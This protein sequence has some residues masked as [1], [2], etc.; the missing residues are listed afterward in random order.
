MKYVDKSFAL[1]GK[2]AQVRIPLVETAWRQDPLTT[3]ITQ[4]PTPSKCDFVEALAGITELSILGDHTRWY[5]SVGLD[6][7]SI[8]HGKSGVPMDCEHIYY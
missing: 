5:E 8:T 7:V 1:D 3:L 6:Q 2:A 4:W